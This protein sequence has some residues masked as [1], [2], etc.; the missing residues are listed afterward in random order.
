MPTATGGRT[1]ARCS[2]PSP[3][4]SNNKDA[5]TAVSAVAALP[6]SSQLDTVMED[7]DPFEDLSAAEGA[8]F[9]DASVRCCCYSSWVVVGKFRDL[10]TFDTVSAV[11]PSARLNVCFSYR[12]VLEEIERLRRKLN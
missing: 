4:V 9:A 5:G 2:T 8:I 12:T 6:Q 7:H 10:H 1:G 3:S 11:L